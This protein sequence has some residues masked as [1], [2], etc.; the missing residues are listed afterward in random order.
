VLLEN[1]T[2]NA[3]SWNEFREG[4]GVVLAKEADGNYVV[5]N[6]SDKEPFPGRIPPER[7]KLLDELVQRDAK[8]MQEWAAFKKTQRPPR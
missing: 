6:G 4:T 7:L 3:I 1:A 2:A 5:A 8:N